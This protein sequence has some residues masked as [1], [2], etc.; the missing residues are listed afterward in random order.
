[1]YIVDNL[2]EKPFHIRG[3]LNFAVLDS[4]YVAIANSERLN[5]DIS[6]SYQM[7]LKDR[8][9]ASAVSVSTSDDKSIKLRITKAFEILGG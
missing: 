3:P 5:E 8:E 2:G 7:L 4:V 9:Y 6:L 1:S